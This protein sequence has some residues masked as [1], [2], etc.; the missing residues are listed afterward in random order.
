MNTSIETYTGL[1]FD[2]SHPDPSM[3]RIEDIAHSLSMLCRYNGHCKYFYSVAQHSVLMTGLAEEEKIID[4]MICLL[5]DAAEA[6]T[7]DITRPFK[8]IINDKSSVL[9]EIEEGVNHAIYKAFNL[10][11]PSSK[12]MESVHYA[13][14][15][16]MATEKRDLMNENCKWEMTLPEPIVCPI[17]PWTSYQAEYTFLKVFNLFKERV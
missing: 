3:V 8:N 13:D 10:T 6:Y 1:L 16:M 4:P 11:Y 14:L 17:I 2:L 7:G 9:K 15:I 12:E 5:H